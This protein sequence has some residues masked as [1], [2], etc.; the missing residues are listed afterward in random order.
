MAAPAYPTCLS[1]LMPKS[2]SATAT[3]APTADP[4]PS[5]ISVSDALCRAA[6]ECCR[7]HDRVARIVERSEVDAEVAFAQEFCEMIH[8]GLG[9]LLD[10]Y[11]RAAAGA[12]TNPEAWRQAATVLHRAARDYLRRHNDCDQSAR[13][14][15][16]HDS[17]LL[18]TLALEFEFEASALLALRH[19]TEAY[20][21]E[22]PE[23]A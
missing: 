22:R 10:V 17:Q 19:A 11:E 21:K 14:L 20:Q 1:T 15:H 4:P 16:R 13:R 9:R 18:A 3:A 7:Q 2:K 5:L 6:G 12:P 23:A 8:T